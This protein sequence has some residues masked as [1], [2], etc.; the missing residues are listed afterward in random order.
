MYPGP[1]VG[2]PGAAPPQ[3]IM[4]IAPLSPTA[5]PTAPFIAPSFG[6]PIQTLAGV[7]DEHAP[8]KELPSGLPELIPG[9]DKHHGSEEHEIDGY[10]TPF[11]PNHGGWYTQGEF[12]LM[13]PTTNDLDLAIVN[14]GSGLSTVGP[15][16]SIRNNIGTGLR[17]EAGYRYCDG[18]WES[19]FGFTYLHAG[20]NADI[21]AGPGAVLLP[22]RTRPGLINRA[23]AATGDANLDY[24]LYD[25]IIARRVL[26]D[27]HFGLRWLGGLRFADIRQTVNAGYDGADARQ[28]KVSERSRF[29]GVGPMVGLEAVLAGWKGFHL[30]SRATGGLIAGR[31]TNAL[32]EAN[33]AGATTYIDTHYDI[34]KVVPTGSLAVGLGWQYRTIAIRAGYEVAYWQGI[35]DRPRFTDDVSQG[36]FVARSANLALDGWFMQV[37]VSY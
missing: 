36:K 27:E 8:M 37:A 32:F 13:R 7:A 18:K 30:Y 23:L 19:A 20:A 10:M 5:P 29:Q 22:T 31:N 24:Q 34:R 1:G 21:N 6:Q 15:I 12:L 2:G 3:A 4:P 28:A 14:T 25:M 26:Q 33:D 9:P 16:Q 35:F 17:V 11:I